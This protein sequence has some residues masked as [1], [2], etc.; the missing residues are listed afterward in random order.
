MTNVV[1]NTNTIWKYASIHNEHI[2]HF[3]PILTASIF[4]L[5][6]N[7]LEDNVYFQSLVLFFKQFLFFCALL[8]TIFGHVSLISAGRKQNDAERDIPVKESIQISEQELVE[9]VAISLSSTESIEEPYPLSLVIITRSRSN[10]DDFVP[11]SRQLSCFCD[12]SYSHKTTIAYSGFRASDGFSQYRPCPLRYPHNGSTES[13]V[14]AA[15]LALAYTA[16]YHYD[17]VVIHTDNSKVEQLFTGPRWKDRRDY[18]RFF[19]A[20]DQCQQRKQPLNIRVKRVPGHPTPLEQ[21][22]CS[23]KREFAK[24]DRKVRQKRRKYERQ[25]GWD[26]PHPS[27]NQRYIRAFYPK[28]YDNTLVMTSIR[29][30]SSFSKL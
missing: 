30:S 9:T 18:P 7:H 25:I 22:Q 21:K 10:D 17:A 4:I 8:V 3:Q 12:G 16:A 14:Y 26:T 20:L 1:V 5:L 27:S 2:D 29:R 23:N 6:S 28:I 24:V 15:S 11:S 13:E 19:N